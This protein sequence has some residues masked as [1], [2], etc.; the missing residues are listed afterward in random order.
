MNSP[1]CAQAL[2]SAQLILSYHL[3]EGNTV[4]DA[5]AGNGHDTLFLA[6]CVGQTGKVF[7]FDIQK[8]ALENTEKRLVEAGIESSRY[9]LILESHARM[10]SLTLPPLHAAMFNLGYLPGS[11]KSCTTQAEESLSALKAAQHLLVEGGLITLAC[12]IGHDGGAEEASTLSAYLK[13]LPFSE[14]LITQTTQ[15]NGSPKAPFLFILQKRAHS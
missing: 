15:F 14:W 2:E 3:Q 8:K 12:Y 13:S 7:A 10:A 11:D 5:T 4:L 1:F 9:T 6:Q